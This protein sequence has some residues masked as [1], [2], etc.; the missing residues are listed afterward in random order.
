[1]LIVLVLFLSV[2]SWF[3]GRSTG[4]GEG[5]PLGSLIGIWIPLLL[6]GNL[7]ILRWLGNFNL[8]A[9]T[10]LG[11]YLF[12]GALVSL[13]D[14]HEAPLISPA[15]MIY[16]VAAGLLLGPRLGFIAI[17]VVAVGT[18][19]FAVLEPHVSE[20]LFNNEPRVTGLMFGSPITWVFGV[21]VFNAIVIWGIAATR[22]LADER[23]RFLVLRSELISSVSHELR[24]PI[25]AI[26]GAISLIEGGMVGPLD[27]QAKKLIAIAKCNSDLLASLV[28]DILDIERMED[29]NFEFSVEE[30]NLVD[31]VRESIELNEM[32]AQS[33]AVTFHLLDGSAIAKV[34]AN[35]NRLLQVLANLLSNA[36]KFSS[37]N[38][39]VEISVARRNGCN[40]VSVADDGLGV[41]EKFRNRVFERF[42]Q[43]KEARPGVQSGTGLGLSIAK[44][45]VEAHEGMI[46]FYAN[47]NGGATFYFDLPASEES[48][49]AVQD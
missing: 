32:Y 6:L 5:T 18:T 41:P 26:A 8:A 40:R 36:A 27:A 31:L 38:G 30:L 10:F 48:A 37:R 47:K 12:Y 14:I 9:Y 1:M 42:S 16:P 28:D 3:V 29:G 35:K 33:F 25:T 24:T 17:L 13:A 20:P 4:S 34:K 21:A 45:I 11:E 19:G 49:T 39:R 46:E 2:I 43:S 7:A 44:S 22:R 15:L 23:D